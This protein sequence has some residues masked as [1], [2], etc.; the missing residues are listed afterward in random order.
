[1]IVKHANPCG[2]AVADD[3]T[4]AYTS[5]HDCDPV[6]AFGGIVALNRPVPRALAEG[7][8]S[9]TWAAT[10]PPDGPLSASPDRR[11]AEMPR[12]RITAANPKCPCA[13]PPA[14]SRC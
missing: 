9:I 14:P 2:A 5:A 11:E 1:M 10:L 8:A 6:S 12:G 7:A 4:T 13:R 3:I